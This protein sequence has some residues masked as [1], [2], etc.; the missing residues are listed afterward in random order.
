MNARKLYPQV[1]LARVAQEHDCRD[2]EVSAISAHVCF[3]A[4]LAMAV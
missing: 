3:R 1:I 2:G 4:I